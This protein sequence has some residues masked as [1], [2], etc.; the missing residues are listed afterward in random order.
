MEEVHNKKVV[1]LGA[2][3]SGMAAASLLRELGSHVFVSDIAMTEK[4]QQEIKILEGLGIPFEFGQHSEKIYD[5]DFIV[6]SPGIPLTSTV[7]QSILKKGIP[8][9]SEVEVASWFCQSPIIAITGSNGKTTT[10]TLLGEILRTEMPDA[11][12]AGNIGTPFSNQVLEGKTTSWASVEISSFQL[13]TIKHFHPKVAIILNL[14]PNH[15]D[16]YESFEDYVKAKLRILINLSRDDYLIYNGDDHFLQKKLKSCQA[17]KLYFSLTDEKADALIK[18]NTIFLEKKS[19]IPTSQILLKG[20]HNYMNAMAA[21]LAA[22]CADISDDSIV[23]VLQTFKGVEHRLEHVA[24]VRDVRFIN[25]SKATTIES[26]TVALNSFD[27]P[28]ILIAGGKDKGSDYSQIN[29]LIRKKVREVFLIGAAQE[30]IASS[31]K[32]ITKINFAQN[33]EEAVDDA[34]NKAYKGDVILLSP[35]CSSFD[36]F[37]DFEDRG[38]KFKQIVSQ[39]VTNYENNETKK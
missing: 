35:A 14:A 29:E 38:R 25:D 17:K 3:R 6:L 15:L 13:E 39:I 31:W 36:M 9:Y 23:G 37:H 26:L 24:T 33:L 10:T 16:W 30:R 18:R 8:I 19:L 12:I 4:K 2:A 28:I 7:V 32:N 20:A 27:T 21:C 11:I 5:T 1:I 34:F 22:R